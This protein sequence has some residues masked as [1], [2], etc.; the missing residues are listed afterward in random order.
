[1]QAAALEGLLQ[2]MCFLYPRAIRKTTAYRKKAKRGFRRK[3]NKAL[4]F[5]YAELINIASELHWFPPR[6][7]VVWG[8]RTNL[9]GF[10]HELRDLRNHV[11]PGL[12]APKKRPVKFTKGVFNVAFEIFEVANSWL[13][14]Y[15][16]KSIRKRTE[17]EVLL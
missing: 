2:T 14:H 16:E 11:H 6:K 13:L 1:M 17:R 8:K 10:V 5:N 4:D 12:L 3:R 7:M 9:A 15:V